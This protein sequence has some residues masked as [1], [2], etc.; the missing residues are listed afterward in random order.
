M[1]KR[2]LNR[3]GNTK[4]YQCWADIRKR[5]KPTNKDYRHYAGRGI[6]LEFSTY[7][8]FRE[9]VRC[10]PGLCRHAVLDR[11][12]NDG[13]YAVGNLRW[14]DWATSNRNRRQQIPDTSIKW[15]IPELI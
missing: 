1:Y 6:Q 13:N 7:H 4:L 12:N 2:K 5:M 3:G 11:I 10:L 15:K 8:D 9:Y 14:V